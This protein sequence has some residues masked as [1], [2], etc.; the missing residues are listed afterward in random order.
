[1][2]ATLIFNADV[3]APTH[4]GSFLI[5]AD[6]HLLAWDA[7]LSKVACGVRLTTAIALADLLPGGEVVEAIQGVLSG[8]ESA[9]FTAHLALPAGS[10]PVQ[11]HVRRMVS[12]MDLLALITIQSAEAQPADVQD[13]LTGVAS[14]GAVAARIGSWRESADACPPFAL[15]FLDLDDFKRINDEHGHAAGDQV[16]RTLAARWTSCLRDNDLV[17]RYGGD[18]FVILLKDV[19]SEADAEPI[20]KRLLA[21]T[22]EPIGFRDLTLQI[23]ATIGVASSTSA[24]TPVEDLIDQADRHMYARKPRRP[25]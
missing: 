24:P 8:A 20:V 21:A 5:D 23:D 9:C 17:A 13:P 22:A 4:L 15:L 11:V 16:L 10:H 1:M 19:A 6:L 3:Q 18:E 14:R 2:M 12:A 7:V 25:R